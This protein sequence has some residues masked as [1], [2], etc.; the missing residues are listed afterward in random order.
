MCLCNSTKL[1]AGYLQQADEIDSQLYKKAL[2]IVRENGFAS[3]RLLQRALK[4]KYSHAMTVIAMMQ[5]DGLIGP[6][7]SARRD[8][9]API[10]DLLP[11]GKPPSAA[12]R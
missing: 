1:N 11:P 5:R 4:I 10:Y 7:S 6:E 8:G 3:T 12:S 9:T 2:E